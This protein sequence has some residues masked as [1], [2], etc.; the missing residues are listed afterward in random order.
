[1]LRAECPDEAM[2]CIQDRDRAGV[3]TCT[4]WRHNL[5]LELARVDAILDMRRRHRRSNYE[6]A[7]LFLR[8]HLAQV[9]TIAGAARS[10][11]SASVVR[12]SSRDVVRGEGCA[13]RAGGVRMAA[14]AGLPA[15][16]QVP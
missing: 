13:C 11:C 15:S 10:T 16:C 12:P 7:G 1:M 2:H 5:P 9:V 3:N 14:A 6:H 4:L 8:R